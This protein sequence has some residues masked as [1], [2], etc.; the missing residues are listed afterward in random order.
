MTLH[1]RL[2]DAQ[3][4]QRPGTLQLIARGWLFFCLASRGILDAVR[5]NPIPSTDG[6][7]LTA[8]TLLIAIA[9]PLY[10]ATTWPV[11]DSVFATVPASARATAVPLAV[12][13]FWMKCVTLSVAPASMTVL[14]TPSSTPIF[15]VPEVM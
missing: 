12:S 14:P 10:N 1:Q 11:L 2:P 9:A 8:E 4:P 3:Q 5:K 7:V 6:R 15:F 13:A